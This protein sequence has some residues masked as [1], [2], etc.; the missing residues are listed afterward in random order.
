[1]REEIAIIVQG[2]ES[3]KS[4]ADRIN[5]FLKEKKADVF[6]LQF[7]SASN[8]RQTCNISLGYKLELV[9]ENGFD[10]N[11]HEVLQAFSKGQIDIWSAKRKIKELDSVLKEVKRKEREK[12]F[13]ANQEQVKI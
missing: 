13:Q 8:G 7:T 12:N 9:M 10:W 5:D 2:D 1:M 4:F 3:A 11:L 6:Q